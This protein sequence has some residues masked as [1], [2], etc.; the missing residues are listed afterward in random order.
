M[1]DS[2]SSDGRLDQILADFLAA[3]ERGEAPS[4]EKLVRDH[5]EFKAEIRAFLSN[6]AH[7]SFDESTNAYTPVGPKKSPRIGNF[8]LLQRLGEGGMGEVW[9]ADQ[10]KPVRRRV[11][12]KLIKQGMDSKAVLARF[13]AERQALALMNHPNIAKVF[14]AGIETGNRNDC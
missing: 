4:P 8:K 6:Q 5:P 9:M 11:A 14:E 12:V 7:F 2:N 3:Q 10:E 13:D 1:T